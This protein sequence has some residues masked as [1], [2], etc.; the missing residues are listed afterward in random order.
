MQ[1]IGIVISSEILAKIDREVARQNFANP[2]LRQ[3]RSAFVREAVNEYLGA[4]HAK[5]TVIEHR[6]MQRVAPSS[7]A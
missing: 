6:Q 4:L 1:T 5:A 7:D 2:S 3:S